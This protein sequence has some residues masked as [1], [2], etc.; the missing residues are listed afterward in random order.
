[1]NLFK[2]IRIGTT[3]MSFGITS[4]LF[5]SGKMHN[6]MWSFFSFLM[7]MFL[8]MVKKNKKNKYLYL[9]IKSF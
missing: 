9:C 3:T 4:T 8:V 5:Y 7:L 6:A 1:M 2:K